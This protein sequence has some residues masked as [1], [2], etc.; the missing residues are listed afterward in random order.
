MAYDNLW[1]Q[2]SIMFC[3][4]HKI[5]RNVILK[6]RHTP[7][8]LGQHEI[9]AIYQQSFCLNFIDGMHVY[10]SRNAEIFY[11]LVNHVTLCSLFQTRKG[12]QLFWNILQLPSYIAR[13]TH[14][15]HS[16]GH[17]PVCHI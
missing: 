3:N 13:R 4:L 8:P 6:D 10:I 17:T 2:K 7:A 15:E 16:Q 1:L 5:I 11:R 14:L 9:M 12:R